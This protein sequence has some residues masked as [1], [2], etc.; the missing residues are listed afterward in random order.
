[1]TIT[2]GS[3]TPKLNLISWVVLIKSNMAGKV[4]WRLKKRLSVPKIDSGY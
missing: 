2:E 3:G 4:N 1:M